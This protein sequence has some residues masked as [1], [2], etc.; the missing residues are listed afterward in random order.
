MAFR[1]R[2]GYFKYKVISFGLANISAIFQAYINRVLAD[3][4]DVN[5]VIYLDDIL[6]YL[7][8]RAEYQQYIRQIFERL[9]QYKLYIKLSKCEFSI[10]SIIFLG[11]VINIRK[12]E[13][14]KSRVEIII[15]WPESKSFRDIQVF[16]NFA[17]FYRR[18]IRNYSRIAASLTS[19]F[20]ENINGRKIDPF[21]FKEVVRIA[22]K[23]LKI[24]FTR[25]LILIHFN[26]NKSIKIFQD[27]RLP[28]YYYNKLISSQRIIHRYIGN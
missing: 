22:F 2:Y 26:S 14:D 13:M 28:E 19:I 12:I 16:L 4:I 1:I 6:I 21:E 7:I 3:L 25:A 15:E 18:F 9:R 24:S 11:F 23:L 5:C 17:N 10:I 20:K 27:S 8:N